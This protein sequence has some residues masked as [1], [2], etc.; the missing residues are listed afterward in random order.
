MLVQGIAMFTGLLGL[1]SY[2]ASLLLYPG[3]AEPPL[4]WTRRVL[5][6]PEERLFF[7]M[8]GM[9]TAAMLVTA[10]TGLGWILVSPHTDLRIAGLF[11]ALHV[12][13]SLA[14]ALVGLFIARAVHSDRRDPPAAAVSSNNNSHLSSLP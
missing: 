14:S 6:L 8:L 12:L 10:A 7:V 2:L 13:L 5:A 9:G 1:Q 4:R 11:L 3:A